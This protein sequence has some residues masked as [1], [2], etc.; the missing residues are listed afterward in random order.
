MRLPQPIIPFRA[1]PQPVQV[2][3]SGGGEE[4]EVPYIRCLDGRVPEC[5]EVWALAEDRVC[6]VQPYAR[7]RLLSEFREDTLQNIS[8]SMRDD[9]RFL[10]WVVEL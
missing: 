9:S 8:S 6:E 2:L 5:Y 7:V 1:P 10:S 3:R 4:I